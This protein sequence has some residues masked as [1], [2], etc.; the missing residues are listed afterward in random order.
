MSS[1]FPVCAQMPGGVSLQSTL[2]IPNNGSAWERRGRR[3]RMWLVT[4]KL[5]PT[6]TPVI[7]LGLPV[8]F[9]DPDTQM[10]GGSKDLSVNTIIPNKQQ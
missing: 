3:T 2:H 6:P 1:P 8:S 10:R 7:N 9:A 4:L 5:L